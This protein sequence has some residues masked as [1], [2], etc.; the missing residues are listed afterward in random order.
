MNAVALHDALIV[1]AGPAGAA[2]ARRLALQGREVLLVEA[3]RFDTARVGETLAPDIQPEL[4]ELGLRDRFMQLQPL[5]SWGVRSIWSDAIPR[6]RS[7]LSSPWCSGWHVDRAAFDRM[8]AEGARDAGADMIDGCRLGAVQHDGEA[9]CIDAAGR[10]WR[11]RWLVDA[12]GRSARIARQLGAHR[13]MFDALIGVSAVCAAPDHA[14]RHHLLVETVPEGWWYSAPLPG[15]A[16]E[17]IAILMTD[18]DLCVR[19]GL[20]RSEGWCG[21]IARSALTQGRVDIKRCAAPKVFLARSH[22]LLRARTSG[23]GGEWLAV[24]DAA[25]AVDPLSG[26]GVLRALR[27]ARAAAEAIAGAIERPES[28][29]EAIAE[30]DAACDSEC[31][32]YLIERAQ[33][34]GDA[35]PFEAPFW[36]RRQRVRTS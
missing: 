30:F 10:R 26:S 13:M 21:A 22:R 8:L 23:Q 28:A 35:R 17:T 18:S 16:P 11:S 33:H 19:A 2:L 29:G 6:E 9:W 31:T 7:H 32:S 34:Y 27:H 25:L 5:P 12:T 15:D 1:G 14:D 36:K 20:H 3:T 24:G 4:G